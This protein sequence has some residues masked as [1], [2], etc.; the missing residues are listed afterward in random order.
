[1]NNLTHKLSLT[2]LFPYDKIPFSD[3]F[4]TYLSPYQ[5]TYWVT[6]HSKSNA[7]SQDKGKYRAAG[8]V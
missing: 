8:H 2:W 7:E 4:Q 1:M 6:V 5:L 3:N